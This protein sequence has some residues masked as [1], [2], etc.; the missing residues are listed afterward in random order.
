MSF[1]AAI[2]KDSNVTLVPPDGWKCVIVHHS[3][4]KLHEKTGI[5]FFSGDIS[6]DKLQN[7]QRLT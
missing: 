3:R 4:M 6:D 2:W 5:E 1:N 7:Y